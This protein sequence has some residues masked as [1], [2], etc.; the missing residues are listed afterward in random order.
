MN[1]TLSKSY[2]P[3]NDLWGL[4][5]T[6]K[7]LSLY[8]IKIS[9]TRIK[10]L[11]YSLFLYPK[12]HIPD[13][14][15]MHMS[16]LKY[17]L[18]VVQNSL[19]ITREKISIEKEIIEFLKHVT[20]RENVEF[21][22]NK[23]FTDIDDLI[24]KIIFFHMELDGDGKEIRIIDQEFLESDF[25]N[26]R[27]IVLQQ[28]GCSI[29]YVLEYD[30]SLEENLD[31]LYSDTRNLTFTDNLVAFASKMKVLLNNDQLKEYTLHQFQMHFRSLNAVEQYELF[32][33]LEISGQISAKSGGELIKNY[34]ISLG[35]RGR[36][37]DLYLNPDHYLES[38]GLADLEENKNLGKFKKGV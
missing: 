20:K 27:E 29:E 1:T 8:P 4:P 14:K 21:S 23:N 7:N 13:I 11:F 38:S 36:Y 25:D 5:Q 17:I 32:K 10:N 19:D 30:P 12:H 26:I 34:L 2:I 6:Y 22:Y 3:E 33:P 18:F 35:Q 37:D 28:N 9:E 31:F 16:Y 24:I 15:I